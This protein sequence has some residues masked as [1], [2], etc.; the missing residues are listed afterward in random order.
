METTTFTALCE[1][2]GRWWT[3]RI[4]QVE[5]L[6]AQV[7]DLGQAEI[8]ARQVISRTLNIP[9][10]AIRVDVLPD[11]PAPVADALRARHAARMAVDAANRATRTALEILAGEGFTF[12]DAATMLGLSPAEIEAYG[13]ARS[14]SGPTSAAAPGAGSAAGAGSSAGSGAGSGSAASS[15]SGSSSGGPTGQSTPPSP[16]P[17]QM[18]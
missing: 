7:R 12:H 11:A 2:A 3:I 16:G 9:A 15:G 4:P 17:L 18:A 8:V 10:E 1:R 5:G 14:V 13:P 6:T